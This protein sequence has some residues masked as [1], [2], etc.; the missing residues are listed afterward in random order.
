MCLFFTP[1]VAANCPMRSDDKRCH[2][3]F[4]RREYLRNDTATSWFQSRGR[5][6]AVVLRVPRTCCRNAHV[7]NFLEEEHKPT[8][9][10]AF[11]TCYDKDGHKATS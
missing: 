6:E 10:L 3:S 11:Q 2:L 5:Q 9:L 4:P 1:N 8:P 7:R